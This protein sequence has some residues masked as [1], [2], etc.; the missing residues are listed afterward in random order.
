[1]VL[2]NL[3]RA[4]P[5]V[6]L[7]A[8]VPHQRHRGGNSTPL[9]IPVGDTITNGPVQSRRLRAAFALR[10]T[11][12]PHLGHTHTRLPSLRAAR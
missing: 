3:A 10:S 2:W 1:M 9:D 7:P 12:S 11:T 8:V 4:T 5:S 6:G